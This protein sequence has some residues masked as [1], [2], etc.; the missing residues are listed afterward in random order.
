MAVSPPPTTT[1]GLPANRN[2]SQVAQLEMPP[3]L[4]SSSPGAPSHRES[5]PVARMSA[6]AV[7]AEPFVCSTKG[8]E[9]TSILVTQSSAKVAENLSAC[10]GSGGGEGGGEQL[11]LERG[12]VQ[13]YF[14]FRL[15]AWEERGEADKGIV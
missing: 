14:C 3:P 1:T 12:G 8:E 10:G 2:P 7:T 11:G 9:E 15:S 4:Y 6:W 5:A 13:A